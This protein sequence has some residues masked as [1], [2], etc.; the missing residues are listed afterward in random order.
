[1][2]VGGAA[3]LQESLSPSAVQA[4]VLVRAPTTHSSSGLL[5]S[6]SSALDEAAQ[7]LYPGKVARVHPQCSAPP[8]SAAIHSVCSTLSSAQAP[9]AVTSSSQPLHAAAPESN[10]ASSGATEQP[11]TGPAGLPAGPDLISFSS[12]ESAAARQCDTDAPAAAQPPAVPLGPALAAHFPQTP[13]LHS[14]EAS[15][16][17]GNSA[18][19]LYSV[20]HRPHASV[21]GLRLAGDADAAAEA[22]AAGAP[23]ARPSQLHTTG[24]G[25]LGSIG[26]LQAGLTDAQRAKEKRAKLALRLELEKQV[27]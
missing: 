15:G 14:P 3:A 9:V 24:G 25:F 1:M 10:R 13:F 18:G 16:M 2:L 7:L 12:G 27:R 20:A 22:A 11:L 8:A 17:S 5:N 23:A 26:Q 19:Q 21:D 6:R 4:S